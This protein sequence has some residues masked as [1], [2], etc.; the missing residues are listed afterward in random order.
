[1]VVALTSP[2][3]RP[4]VL[5]ALLLV[6]VTIGVIGLTARSSPVGT[7][8]SSGLNEVLT[9]CAALVAIGVAFISIVR[10]RL[11]GDPLSLRVG[12]AVFLLAGGPLLAAGVVPTIVPSVR[13]QSAVVAVSAAS[14]V[15][16]LG[17]L[18]FALARLWQQSLRLRRLVP[19][20]V[21]ATAAVAGVL[22]AFPGIARSLGGAVTVE[23][24][25]G[26][27]LVRV[28]LVVVW[29]MVASAY[30]IDALLRHRWLTAWFG[31][32]LFGLA[33]AQVVGASSETRGDLWA[34]GFTLLTFVALLC[35]LHGLNEELKRAHLVQRARLI[36][37]ELAAD[38][39][40]A[41]Y[42]TERTAREEQAH[43]T[44]SAI[45]AIG[46]TA[47][48]LEV[49]YHELEPETTAALARAL[50]DEI[51]RVQRLNET[52]REPVSCTPFN[53]A[54][55]LHSV[56]V[57]CRS[58]G[59]RVEVDLPASLVADGRPADVAQ[60][61]HCLL[62]NA[63]RHAAG[64]LVSV[65]GMCDD[66]RVIVRVEDSG[67]GIDPALH[68]E[69]FTRAVS[70]GD[71]SGLGLYVARRLAREQGGDLWVDPNR[72]SGAAFVLALPA[73]SVVRATPEGL[74]HDPVDG[75][76]LD[77]LVPVGAAQ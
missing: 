53:V 44:R 25:V 75:R 38:A 9:P 1:V 20:T 32:S 63:A 21:A 17:I 66:S 62:A 19:L 27:M 57:C 12:I 23:P 3:G 60:I 65:R 41:R 43:D 33:L 8:D 49:G 14:T 15:V 4:F 45:L 7:V 30:A 68:E 2:R 64:S 6:S 39:A 11:G 36:D 47:R 40:Y 10:W 48:A 31:L 71:G 56:L 46:A 52:E 24:G 59:L 51:G 55:A 28:L 29:T 42:R 77:C 34:T 13:G 22:M 35:A 76:H 74:H 61:V 5:A 73:V 72:R 16:A 69:I 67:P 58:G 70:H 26:P 50:C 18:T 37:S 54:D